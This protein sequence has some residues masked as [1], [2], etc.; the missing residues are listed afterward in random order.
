MWLFAQFK[1]WVAT[2][3]QRDHLRIILAFA[4]VGTGAG[5]G[6]GLG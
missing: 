6:A 1:R 4:G 3:A 5:G 2:G